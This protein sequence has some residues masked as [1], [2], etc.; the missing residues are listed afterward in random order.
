MA[1]YAYQLAEENL[2]GDGRG[3]VPAPMDQRH[4][5]SLNVE[6]RMQMRPGLPLRDSALYLRFV[7]GSGLPYTPKLL[8]SV[9]DSRWVDGARHGL[10]YGM[11]RR[12]DVGMTQELTVRGWQ[13]T[14]SEEVANFFDE[15]NVVGMTYAADPSGR[16]VAFPRGLGRRRLNLVVTAAW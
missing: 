11:Y 8:A 9:S 10:R 12:L 2:Q 1:S 16:P 4:T 14:V 3:H 6:E 5:V 13:I 15:F 7:Y